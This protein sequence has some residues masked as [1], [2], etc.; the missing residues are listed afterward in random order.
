MSLTESENA[1]GTRKNGDYLLV[2]KLC[3]QKE[4]SVI[5]GAIPTYTSRAENLRILSSCSFLGSERSPYL[6]GARL[7][8]SIFELSATSEYRV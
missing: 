4:Q 3:H 1:P 6:K 7:E 2:L 8:K 5:E